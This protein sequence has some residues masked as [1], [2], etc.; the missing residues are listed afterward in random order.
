[1]SQ[2]LRTLA[3]LSVLLMSSAAVLAQQPK[4]V[5]IGFVSWWAPEMTRHVEQVRQGL[6]DFGYVDGKN[7][8][9]ESYFTNG[10]REK[11]REVLGSLVDRGVDILIVSTTPAIHIAKELTQKIPVVMAPVADPVSTGLVQSLAHPGGNLTGIT[12]VGADLAGKRLELLREIIPDIRTVAFL[13]STRDPNTA[14]FVRGT[15]AAADKIGIKL[16]EK[17]VDG[18][19]AIDE[20]VFKDM[21]SDGV[22]AVVVQ[23]IFMGTQN[24]IVSL[25]MKAQLPVI[26][27]FLL[28]AEAGA[29]VTYGVDDDGQLRRAAYYVDRIL[30]GTSPADL[31]IEGPTSFKLGVN[32]A[33]AKA[34]GLTI[35][36]SL[37]F[38]A[39]LVIE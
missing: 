15:K 17:M 18:P 14:T 23:P 19:G 12:M 13:G 34:L 3:G 36:Q 16:I 30:K 1:M 38:R 28:F 39:D 35:P 24:K 4:M 26:S 22:Q 7:I 27:D 9:F 32:T 20:T 25:A 29:L 5:K 2:F 33:T 11:T 8:E 37:L 10:N 21:K 6:L 31:P